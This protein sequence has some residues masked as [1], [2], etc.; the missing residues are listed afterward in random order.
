MAGKALKQNGTPMTANEFAIVCN[1]YCYLQ[2]S[3]P[4]HKTPAALTTRKCL[5]LV[6]GVSDKVAQEAIRQERAN[7]CPHR[8]KPKN[9]INFHTSTGTYSTYKNMFWSVIVQVF[10]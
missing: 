9:P 3:G 2:G 1:V 5:A 8:V 7:E 4:A 6:T 10:Q